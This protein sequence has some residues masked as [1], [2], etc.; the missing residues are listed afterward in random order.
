MGLHLCANI[1]WNS[2]W[3]LT[4]MSTCINNNKKVYKN[5]YYDVVAWWWCGYKLIGKDGRKHWSL[6]NVSWFKILLAQVPILKVQRD[7]T[8][9]N[10]SS[11]LLK[12]DHESE[13]WLYE[14]LN[15]MANGKFHI[16]M[17]KRQKGWQMGNSPCDVK[18][19]IG[20]SMGNSLCDVKLGPM[21]WKG[22]D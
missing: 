14:R 9:Q 20:R 22:I 1:F 8:L 21:W 10:S 4:I 3:M 2:N 11:R 15:G 17:L 5:M 19:Q 16:L 13:R 12:R 18:G 7:T 6:S